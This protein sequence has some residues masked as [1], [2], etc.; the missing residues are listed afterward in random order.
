MGL[1]DWIYGR[2][3]RRP[4]RR[5]WESYRKGEVGG[6]SRQRV[7][8]LAAEGL[9]VGD[10]VDVA[11]HRGVVAKITRGAIEPGLTL[12]ELRDG[13]RYAIGVRAEE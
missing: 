3:L 5:L 1:G 9:H 11:G 6:D 8:P 13:R 7:K 10:V 4:H 2:L 12:V